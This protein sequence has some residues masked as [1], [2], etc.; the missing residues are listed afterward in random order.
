M[1][2]DGEKESY[3]VT[4]KKKTLLAASRKSDS[5]KQKSKESAVDLAKKILKDCNNDLNTLGKKAVV[6]LKSNYHG[7][8]EAKAIN[9]VAS[10]ELGRRRKLQE[11]QEKV[12][13]TQSRDVCNLFQPVLGDLPH[14]E[15]WILLPPT[16]PNPSP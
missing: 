7:V 10:L 1:N 8:G 14:E 15:F 12:K 13:I 5:L 11:N 4:R 2:E 9:V 6:D 3:M 16:T